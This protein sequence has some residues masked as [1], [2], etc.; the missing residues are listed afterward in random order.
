M[1]N[2]IGIIMVVLGVMSADSECLLIPLG[3]IVAGVV[4]A[5]LGME[6]NEK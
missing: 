4:C 6:V 5:I 1:L 3:I 2:K